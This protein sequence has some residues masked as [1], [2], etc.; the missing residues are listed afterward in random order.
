MTRLNKAI[1][2]SEVGNKSLL[3]SRDM[4]EFKSKLLFAQFSTDRCEHD[5]EAQKVQ[6]LVFPCNRRRNSCLGGSQLT[7]R[8]TSGSKVMQ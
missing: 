3:V 8:A 1:I 2:N 6:L 4:N 7:T 5:V